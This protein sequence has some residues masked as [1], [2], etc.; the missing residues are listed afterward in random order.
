MRQALK[1]AGWTALF[2]V[3]GFLMLAGIC[4]TLEGL[5]LANQAYYQTHTALSE[6]DQ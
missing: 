1:Y 6:D 2:V 4:W 3:H 5:A